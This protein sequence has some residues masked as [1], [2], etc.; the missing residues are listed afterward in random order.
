MLHDGNLAGIGLTDPVTIGAL[1]ASAL[2]MAAGEVLKGA[3]GEAVKDAYASLKRGIGR[4]AGND[5]E[6]L[7]KAP[8]SA[9]R[10][11]IIAEVVDQQ[12]DDDKTATRELAERLITALRAEGSVGL[13]VGQLDALAVKLGNISV[14]GGVGV[15][16]R[17]AR[18][19]GTFETGDITAGSAQKKT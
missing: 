6:A 9:G 14:S 1:A 16:I 3:V 19:Q 7:E 10:Q 2:S 12:S 8:A 11:Q 17:E 4:W 13:D 18:V 15:R 5:V